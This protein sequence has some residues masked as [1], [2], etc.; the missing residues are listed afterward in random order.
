MSSYDHTRNDQVWTYDLI[1]DNFKSIATNGKRNRLGKVIHLEKIPF[2][3]VYQ[4]TIQHI[5]STFTLQQ[6]AKF[7]VHLQLDKLSTVNLSDFENP[8]WVPDPSP[9]GTYSWT[10][11]A[12]IISALYAVLNYN[13]DSNSAP[14]LEIITI[15]TEVL[16]MK[17][18]QVC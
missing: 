7:K 5:Y 17:I 16:M 13:N 4:Y 11:L 2:E 1:N 3:Q 6:K 8:N 18:A 9:S 10:N 15:V 14:H 12:Q